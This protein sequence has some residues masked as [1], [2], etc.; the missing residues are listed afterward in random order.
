MLNADLGTDECSIYPDGLGNI[1]ISTRMT[2]GTLQG[3]YKISENQFNHEYEKIDIDTSDRLALQECC[4][5]TG[6]GIVLRT[7]A[8]DPLGEGGWQRGSQI[9]EISYDFGITFKK[10]CDISGTENKFS[11][12][13]TSI[14]YHNNELCVV[15]EFTPYSASSFKVVTIKALLSQSIS[16]I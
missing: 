9:L 3:L 10:I 13:Y 8:T 16:L 6:N 4:L 12:G 15:Y 2:D 1:L 11:G 14:S 5:Y 7:R